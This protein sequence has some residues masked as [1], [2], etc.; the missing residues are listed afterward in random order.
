MS[1]VP[2]WLLAELFKP[3]VHESNKKNCLDR[4]ATILDAHPEAA[5]T[6]AFQRWDKEGLFIANLLEIDP[7]H[8]LVKFVIENYQFYGRRLQT[9]YQ[10]YPL[11]FLIA[12]DCQ[13]YEV[14]NEVTFKTLMQSAANPKPYS[15]E[16]GGLYFKSLL[17]EEDPY[18]TPDTLAEK[19]TRHHEHFRKFL[20]TNHAAQAKLKKQGIE[21]SFWLK[22]LEH[23]DVIAILKQVAGHEEEATAEK[24]TSAQKS[25]SG[26]K[27]HKVE[28]ALSLDD[29]RTR[30]ILQGPLRDKLDEYTALQEFAAA[31]QSEHGINILER[32]RHH[33]IFKGNPGTGKTTLAAVL[34]RY[35][36]E[37][38]FLTE[39]H[40]V[41]VSATA[42]IGQYI[43][44]TAPKVRKAFEAARGGILFIDEI[45]HFNE[46]KFG[47]DAISEL[48]PLMENERDKFILIAAGY[49][50][51]CDQTMALNPGWADRYGD[52]FVFDNFSRNEMADILKLKLKALKIVIDDDALQTA[53]NFL[54]ED[55]QQNAQQYANARTAEKLLAQALKKRAVRHK[56]AAQPQGDEAKPALLHITQADM[57][58]AVTQ[59]KLDR[60]SNETQAGPIGFV[61]FGKTAAPKAAAAAPELTP[62][63]E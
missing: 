52:T 63:P 12:H 16:W 43:G 38:G 59:I 51:E 55:K 9:H 6:I 19:I 20:N 39:G 26:F 4:V 31:A 54:D 37:R 62:A 33:L 58:A 50:K 45:Y 32:N 27:I 46:T 44:Q 56:N 29:Y 2:R 35:F 36:K 53:L 61:S 34:G 24:E 14:L 23:K 40:V 57:K 28:D 22:K 21:L 1:T 13:D 48:I 8:S 15:Y 42:L 3:L 18:E 5:K 25:R 10:A 17:D 41:E 47:A 60:R 49:P 7:R 11:D 30:N